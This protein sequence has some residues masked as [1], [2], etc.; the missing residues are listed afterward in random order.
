[1]RSGAT[2]RKSGH[3]ETQEDR[4]QPRNTY[5]TVSKTPKITTNPGKTKRYGVSGAA[6]AKE[7]G[8]RIVPVA[9][10]AG[11]LWPRRGLR[12]HA[13][14]IRFCIGP[15]I[16]PAGRSPKETNLIAQDWIENKMREISS[17]Y[18]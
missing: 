9:H 5:Q 18:K 16:D 8:C 2:D 14:T 4:A 11:D 12:K 15:P 10:N 13:G 7:F 3:R 1:M 6:V 17:A